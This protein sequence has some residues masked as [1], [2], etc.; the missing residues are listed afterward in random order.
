MEF[1]IA[2]AIAFDIIGFFVDGGEGV[3][4]RAILA[5]LRPDDCYYFE[6]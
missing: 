4:W 1:I 3:L 2:G 6:R 5:P